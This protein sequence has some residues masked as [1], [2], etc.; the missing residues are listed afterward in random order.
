MKRVIITIVVLFASPAWSLTFMGPT[1]SNIEVGQSGIGLEY[2]NSDLDIRL[3]GY[4]V[5][6]TIDMEA[7]AYFARL[8]FGVADGAEISVRLG[9]SEIEEDFPDGFSSGNEFAWGVGTKLT[10]AESGPL[11]VGAV[12]QLTSFAGDDSAIVGPYLVEGEFDAFEIQVAVGPTYRIDSLCIYGGPLLHFIQGDLDGSIGAL[13]LS[14]DVEQESEFGGYVGMGW[15]IAENSSLNVE[16]QF[17]NDAKVVGIS[18]LNRFGAPPKPEKLTV[19]QRP[20]PTLK[21]EPK[22]DASGRI[23]RGYKLKRDASGEP[24]K[25]ENGDFI[26]IPVYEEEQK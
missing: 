12:F 2:S 26:F 18:L 1:T 14:F 13:S 7:T 20:T 16:Y 11:A 4:G 19:T 21:T 8:L 23:I 22:V 24:A 10:F 17:T 3:D 6:A 5:S 15:Q 25:D 9:V